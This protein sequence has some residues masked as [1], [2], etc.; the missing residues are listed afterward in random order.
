[1]FRK[2]KALEYLACLQSGT[3]NPKRQLE[4]QLAK[5]VLNP[6]LGARILLLRKGQAFEDAFDQTTE[7]INTFQQYSKIV[8]PNQ[9]ISDFEKMQELKIVF[10]Q[11]IANK[12]D[13]K[14]EY[15]YSDKVYFGTIESSN[16]NALILP[17]QES[18]EFLIIFNR[19]LWEGLQILSFCVSASTKDQNESVELDHNEAKK[20]FPLF[21]K[22]LKGILLQ[23]EL[24]YFF[25]DNE[26]LNDPLRSSMWALLHDALD[27]FVFGHEYAHFLRGHFMQDVKL[28]PT[29]MGIHRLRSHCYDWWMEYDADMTALDLSVFRFIDNYEKDLAKNS[30]VKLSHLEKKRLRNQYIQLAFEGSFLFLYFMHAIESFTCSIS[31]ETSTHPPTILRIAAL[32]GQIFQ[33]IPDDMTFKFVMN[34]A[35][36]VIDRL[37]YFLSNSSMLPDIPS[38]NANLRAE[39]TLQSNVFSQLF[40]RSHFDVLTDLYRLRDFLSKRQGTFIKAMI[41][42]IGVVPPGWLEIFEQMDKSMKGDQ[43]ETETVSQ[44]LE[45]CIG[46]LEKNAECWQAKRPQK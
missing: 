6:P 34:Q 4:D 21:S 5:N 20:H 11:C 39:F 37:S 10:D 15:N 35:Y 25:S 26:V 40:V 2:S 8:P 17:V 38:D 12:F 44:M 45:N 13:K 32:R 19:S 14:H 31:S 30:T 7:Y 43:L 23:K 46:V 27:S 42:M 29:S 3:T 33:Q 24:P 36:G 9:S 28:M 1:M 22:L 41:E 16:L 18:D